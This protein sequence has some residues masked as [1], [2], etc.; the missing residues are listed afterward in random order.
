MLWWGQ[1]FE[2]FRSVKVDVHAPDVRFILILRSPVHIL[3]RIKSLGGLPVGSNGGP[4]FVVR[5]NR[6][7]RG[8]LHDCKRVEIDALYF[9]TY[10]FTSEELMK[11]H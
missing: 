2:K 3:E 4:C 7:S 10:P 6:Q 1:S 11:N 5:Q 8:R 9:H